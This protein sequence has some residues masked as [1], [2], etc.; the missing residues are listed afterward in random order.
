MGFLP[1]GS[2]W[3]IISL[4]ALIPVVILFVLFCRLLVAF[5]RYLNRK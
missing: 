3:A 4:I 5:I 2:E 1:S